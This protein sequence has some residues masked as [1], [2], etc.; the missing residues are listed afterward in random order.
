MN[1]SSVIL[2]DESRINAMSTFASQL[3]G[4][5][6]IKSYVHASKKLLKG[7]EGGV[8]LPIYDY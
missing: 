5:K 1:S 3:P 4:P 7:E 8:R 6:I 2:P